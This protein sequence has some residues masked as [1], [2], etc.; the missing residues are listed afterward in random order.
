MKQGHYKGVCF[1]RVLI[2]FKRVLVCFK[3]VPMH[4]H[5]ECVH[6]AWV[7]ESLHLQHRLYLKRV[8]LKRVPM[9]KECV[10]AAW[11]LESLHL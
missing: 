9:H 2:Y 10:H 6:A 7:L 3:R 5:K 8:C 4:K 1:K 11:V